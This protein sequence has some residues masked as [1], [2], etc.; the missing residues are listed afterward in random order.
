MSRNNK[1]RKQCAQ[2]RMMGTGGWNLYNL[3]TLP[4]TCSETEVACVMC[5]FYE[6]DKCI[7]NFDAETSWKVAT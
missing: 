7:Q 3:S 6:G 4:P 1:V 2:I 5:G